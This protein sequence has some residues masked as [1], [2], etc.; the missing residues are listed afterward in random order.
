MGITT[1]G[2]KARILE[3]DKNE[4]LISKEDSLKRINLLLTIL[5]VFLNSVFTIQILFLLSVD[6]SKTDFIEVELVASVPRVST[7]LLSIRNDMEIFLNPMIAFKDSTFKIKS[8]L[9]EKPLIKLSKYNYF[10]PYTYNGD[11]YFLYG[12]IQ[13]TYG[14]FKKAFDYFISEKSYTYSLQHLPSLVQVGS[15]IWLYGVGVPAI[16]N[17]DMD[18]SNSLVETTCQR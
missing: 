11:L 4:D 9:N 3:Y 2:G 8:T 16:I 6:N 15:K 14:K 10:H 12:K 1:R 13:K 18:G 17:Q 7:Y 5:T